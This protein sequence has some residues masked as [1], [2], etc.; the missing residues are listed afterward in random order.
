MAFGTGDMRGVDGDVPAW[1]ERAAHGDLSTL[2]VGRRKSRMQTDS[3]QRLVNSQSVDQMLGVLAQHRRSLEEVSQF[4]PGKAAKV[5]DQLV[6]LEPA[7]ANRKAQQQAESTVQSDAQG[8]GTGRKSIKQTTLAGP[9]RSGP[10]NA[11]GGRASHLANQLLKLIHLAEVE[12]RVDDA[13][14]EVRMSQHEPG[15][16]STAGGDAG[17]TEKTAAVNMHQL[18]ADVTQEVMLILEQNNKRENY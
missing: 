8:R 12:R 1:A 17:G 15:A 3:I 18:Y 13:Q 16:G 9:R 10:A 4:L 5:L 11:G 6:N 14:N 2:N 7:A